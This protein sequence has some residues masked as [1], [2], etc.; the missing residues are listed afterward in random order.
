MMVNEYQ[1]NLADLSARKH[2]MSQCE[3]YFFGDGKTGDL[4]NYTPKA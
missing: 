4:P 1:L 2:L 3:R